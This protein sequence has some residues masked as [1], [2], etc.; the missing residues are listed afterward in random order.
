MMRIAVC[1][2]EKYYVE[3]IA[4]ELKLIL[5]E[6]NIKSEIEGFKNGRILLHQHQL[7]P[8][9]VLFLDI[10]MPGVTGFDIA[11]EIRSLSTQ[12]Q[13]IFITGKHDLVYQSFEYHPFYFICKSVEQNLHHDLLHTV[14]KLLPFFK[15]NKMIKISDNTMGSF[16]V[17]LKDILYIQSDKH[18]LLYYL[19]NKDPIPVK[20]RE[21]MS[22]K[23]NEL[24]S[25]DFFKPH[26]RYLVNMQHVGRFD[27]TLN[28]I[29]LS[30]GTS[31]PISKSLRDSAF[32]K[33]RNYLR[34]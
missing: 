22:I 8:F 2:D 10:D 16:Y 27:L 7:N 14:S 25:F 4:N 30:N 24:S 3:R 13:V 21:M 23:E 17:S 18:Y 1:D 29:L 9:D 15:Q 26:R 20:E 28:S 34:R 11:K 6:E 19:A 12:T 33:Y 5:R 32:E 31:I